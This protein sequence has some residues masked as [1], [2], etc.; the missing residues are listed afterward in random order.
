MDAKTEQDYVEML[1]LPTLGYCLSLISITIAMVVSW[2]EEKPGEDGLE[3]SA[4]ESSDEEASEINKGEFNLETTID[5]DFVDPKY[6]FFSLWKWYTVL[7]QVTVVIEICVIILW[8]LVPL[9]PVEQYT[10]ESKTDIK[11]DQED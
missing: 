3:L 2:I 9:I 5:P 10:G 7:Y 6:E 11:I 1:T 4:E 8:G